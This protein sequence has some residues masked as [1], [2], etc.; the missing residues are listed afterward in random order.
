MCIRDRENNVYDYLKFSFD[1]K[2]DEVN[3][4]SLIHISAAPHLKRRHLR[5]RQ[6]AAASAH[7]NTAVHSHWADDP[8]RGTRKKKGNCFGR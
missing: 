4:L 5:N 1:F 8:R 3:K 6:P 2:S 7:R